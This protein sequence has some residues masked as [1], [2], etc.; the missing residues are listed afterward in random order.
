MKKI[1]EETNKY[2]GRQM[3]IETVLQNLE[4]WQ[5]QF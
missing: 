1:K 2:P 5:K 3:R 4:M